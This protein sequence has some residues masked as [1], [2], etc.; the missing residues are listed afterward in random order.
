MAIFSFHSRVGYILYR[1][2]IFSHP[3]LWVYLHTR[4]PEKFLAALQ[5]PEQAIVIGSLWSF[6]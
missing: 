6:P 4:S 2:I 1:R 5:T 3:V